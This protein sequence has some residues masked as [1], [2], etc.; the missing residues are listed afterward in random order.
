M[1]IA[2]D[3]RIL[4]SNFRG[5]I[6][7]YTE[8]LIEQLSLIDRRNQYQL[9]FCG[10]RLDPH[11][12]SPPTGPN[13]KRYVLP[14]P[15]REFRGHAMLWTELALPAFFRAG[16]PDIYHLPARHELTSSTR[17]KKVITVHDLRTLHIQDG[18]PQDLDTL[19]R[20]CERAD[21]VITI[22]GFTRDDLVRAFR[23]PERKITVV[24]LGVDADFVRLGDGQRAQVEALMQRLGLARPYFLSLGLVP[25]KN[26]DGQLEAFARFAHRGDFAL[27]L[28][29]HLGG[30]HVERYRQ[31][32]VE[33][34]IQDD[35]ILPGP[36]SLEELVL[37]YNGAHAFLFPSLLE[38]F[39]IP[40]LEAMACGAPVITSNGSA[41]PE[42]CGGAALLVDPRDSGEMCEAMTRLAEDDS[43]RRDLQ[44]RGLARVAEFSWERM[45]RGVLKVYENL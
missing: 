17:V 25:R 29:G 32:I 20:S 1:R 24:P 10:L 6:L 42:V 12:V 13:F 37:L 39:G 33:L 30:D 16:R 34:G 15:D 18:D 9:L 38:G 35:V 36:V 41:L 14:L 21:H 31:R 11:G 27:V 5:G 7:V 43:L 19:R 3:A 4:V 28:A 8:R 44:A 40:V 26:I 2:I 23:I 22:S 45:A